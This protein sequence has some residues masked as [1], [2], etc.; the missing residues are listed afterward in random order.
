MAGVIDF[1]DLTAGDPATDLSVAWMLLPP[2]TRTAFR[3]AAGDVDEAT[4]GRA[5]AGPW[6]SPSSVLA[7]SADDPPMEAMARRTL[8]AVLADRPS[9]S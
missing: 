7:H 9:A 5:R 2:E 6:A 3:E 1:G 4:W 8:A